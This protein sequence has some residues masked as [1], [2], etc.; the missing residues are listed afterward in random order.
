MTCVLALHLG[1]A[2]Q[3]FGI[4]FPD[5]SKTVHEFALS[6]R[7][8]DHLVATIQAHLSLATLSL[9]EVSHLCTTVGPGPSTACRM[10][11]TLIKTLSQLLGLGIYTVTSLEALL[12]N[13][14]SFDGTYLTVYPSIKPL[15]HAQL[16]RIASGKFKPLTHAFQWDTDAMCTQLGLFQ[17]TV[18]VVGSW[19]D[20]L[21]NRLLDLSGCQPIVTPVCTMAMARYSTDPATQ[22]FFRY[23]TEQEARHMAPLYAYPPTQVNPIY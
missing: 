21:H 9:K 15:Y 3:S 22:H 16:W 14:L 8:S 6:H 10:G 12:L 17:T 20:D 11:L 13:V 4:V 19:S 1:H 23:T 7:Y 2:P 18:Y 5:G